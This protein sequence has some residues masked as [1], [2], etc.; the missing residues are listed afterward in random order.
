MTE[1]NRVKP[2]Y[3]EMVER[4]PERRP[5]IEAAVSE[6]QE[7]LVQMTEGEFWAKEQEQRV[8]NVGGNEGEFT[9]EAEG[10]QA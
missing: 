7:Q 10:R 6:T 3:R 2:H 8:L 9:N 4:M 5:H 1:R